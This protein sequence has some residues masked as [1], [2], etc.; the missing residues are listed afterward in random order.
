MEKERKGGGKYFLQMCFI[1]LKRNRNDAHMQNLNQIP[2]KMKTGILNLTI[3]VKLILLL[4]TYYITFLETY[5]LDFCPKTFQNHPNPLHT[6]STKFIH[7]E[8]GSFE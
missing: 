8:L 7:L 5:L 6:Y 3:L 4:Y 1:L 2:Q